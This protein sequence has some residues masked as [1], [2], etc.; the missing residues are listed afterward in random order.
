MK[1]PSWQLFT[2]CWDNIHIVVLSIMATFHTL[3]ESPVPVKHHRTL[4]VCRLEYLTYT[5]VF[6]HE[7][8]SY[9]S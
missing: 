5:S 4:D 2:F 1:M 3:H 7:Q 8:V 6:H 9:F